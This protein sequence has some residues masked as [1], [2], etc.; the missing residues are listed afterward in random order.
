MSDLKPLERLQP[1]LLDR[2]IDM[3]PNKKR[4]PRENQFLSKELL[5]LAVLRD[6]AWLFNAT[7]P[8]SPAWLLNT[9]RDGPPA[10]LDERTPKRFLDWS[11]LKEARDS[12]LCFG[13]PSLAGETE[14]TL[15][16]VGLEASVRRSILDFEPR[17]VAATLKVKAEAA[18]AGMSH[19]NI[20]GL[21]ISGQLWAHPVPLDL[22]LRTSV[23]L[24]TCQVSVQDLNR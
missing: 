24:E 3:E 13:L 22:L 7:R 15:D 10:W 6:L 18:P 8:R 12:V 4:E 14:S 1:A 21:R 19:H 16:V 23:N 17:I 11:R 20:I 5:R 2:L 9:R